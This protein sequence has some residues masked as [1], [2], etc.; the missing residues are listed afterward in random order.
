MDH[1]IEH[2]GDEQIL[3]PEILQLHIDGNDDERS[4]KEML[5]AILVTQNEMAEDQKQMA[6]DQEQIAEESR[7]GIAELRNRMDEIEVSIGLV[8]SAVGRGG[9]QRAYGAVWIRSRS[10]LQHD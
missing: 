7:A 5:A 1:V 10:S 2:D 4:T 3:V 9:R 8:A 6:E